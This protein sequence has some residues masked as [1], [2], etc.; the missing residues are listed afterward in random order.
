MLVPAYMLAPITDAKTA[1]AFIDALH[2]DDKL[3]H[4]DDSPETIEHYPTHRRTFTAA[5][6]KVVRLRVAEMFA[7]DGYDPFKHAVELCS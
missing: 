3:F 1:D 7:I 6:C 4:F 5:E 2:A